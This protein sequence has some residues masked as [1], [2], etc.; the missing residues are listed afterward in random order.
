MGDLTDVAV[1]IERQDPIESE[2]LLPLVYD[3]LRRLAAHRLAGE[4]GGISL[5]ATDLVHEAYL[6]LKPD[7]RNWDSPEHFFAAAA[8]EMRRILIDRARRRRRVKHGGTRARVELPEL[9]A[10]EPLDLDDL[11]ALQT[12][13][14]ALQQKSPVKAE[15]V[16]LRYFAGLTLD[17]AAALLH[18][19]RATASRYWTYARAWLYDRLRDDSI[20][21]PGERRQ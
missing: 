7:Q 5:G 6:R 3:E 12:A 13:L 18:I 10:A 8:D 2:R 17:E 15:L 9:N 11:L 14:D 19:S 16:K 21:L 20:R 4:T 1:A